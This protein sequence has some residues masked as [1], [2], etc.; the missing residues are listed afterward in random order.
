LAGSDCP[1]CVL[2][3]LQES[4]TTSGLG[5]F[6]TQT[7]SLNF[8]ADVVIA[9][10]LPKQDAYEELYQLSGV[11]ESKILSQVRLEAHPDFA[12]DTTSLEFKIENTENGLIGICHLVFLCT[13]LQEI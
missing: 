6:S 11:I 5:A 8:A 3:P 2:Y 7:R 10:T 4:I 9:I 1:A 13:Y 12:V